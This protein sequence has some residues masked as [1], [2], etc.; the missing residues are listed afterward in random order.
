[1]LMHSEAYR[2][3]AKGKNI[4]ITVAYC[5]DAAFRDGRFGSFPNENYID[6]CGRLPWNLHFP[7]EVRFPVDLARPVR[8]L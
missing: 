7:A 6:A 2:F 3:Q 8:K 1:M 4:V 5:Y